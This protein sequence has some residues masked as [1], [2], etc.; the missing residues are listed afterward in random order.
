M[1][2]AM[3]WLLL[4]GAYDPE[5]RRAHLL[6][7][8]EAIQATDRQSFKDAASYIE[9]VDRNAC[10]SD[11]RRLRTQCLIQA[12]RRNCRGL[13]NETER[14]RCVLYSDVLVTNALSEEQMISEQERHQIMLSSKDYR[15]DLRREL[16]RRY[17][18]LAAEFALSKH[19]VCTSSDAACLVAAIDGHCRDQADRRNIA[20]QDCAAA[21]VRFIGTT[22]SGK[23]L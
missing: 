15:S 5:T 2:L 13:R 8:L 11:F 7:A 16:V 6:E 14:R 21:L 1:T 19:Y 17:G 10:Q 3:F 18:K 9:A 23:P 20:W 4:L 22:S 12:A